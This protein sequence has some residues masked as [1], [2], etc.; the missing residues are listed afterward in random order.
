M[1]LPFVVLAMAAL[2]A[3]AGR[4]FAADRMDTILYGVAYYPEYMPE[5]RL[6]RDVALMQQAGINVVRVGESTWSTWEPRDGEFQC[7]W[8]QGVLDRMHRAGI[9]VIL[10]TP[11]YSIPTWLAKQ[12]PEILVTHNGTAG[13][14]TDPSSPSYPP[15]SMPGYYG[16]RQNYD[17]LNP[18]FLEKAERVIRKIVERFK[19]HPAVIGYQ[20]DNETAPTGVATPYAKQ[21]FL[22]RL[23]RKYET[24]ATINRIWGLVYWGQ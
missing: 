21:A 6:E 3:A 14:L 5:E 13:P 17:F 20:I 12:H 24:P 11:T 1:K 18:Y 2:G 8:M 4:P 16:P 7:D 10:G 19:D 23:K 9:R 15:S 22:A